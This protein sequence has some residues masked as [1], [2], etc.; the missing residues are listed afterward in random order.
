MILSLQC[1]MLPLPPSKYALRIMSFCKCVY[2][3]YSFI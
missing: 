2:L 1:D 3:A